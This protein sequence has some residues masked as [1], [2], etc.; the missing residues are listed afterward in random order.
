MS[1]SSRCPE[2]FPK[3]RIGSVNQLSNPADQIQLP[4]RRSAHSVEP[5]FLV[6]L[7]VRVGLANT[8]DIHKS[9]ASEEQERNDDLIEHVCNKIKVEA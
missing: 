1:G 7:V 3:R 8:D 5:V 2:W 9:D 6:Y 4:V